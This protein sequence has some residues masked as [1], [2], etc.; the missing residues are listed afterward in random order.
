M[1]QNFSL[2]TIVKWNIEHV[3]IELYP[4]DQYAKEMSKNDVI[5]CEHLFIL[6]F[7][8]WRGTVFALRNSKWYCSLGAIAFWLWLKAGHKSDDTCVR[9]SQPRSLTR[10]RLQIFSHVS[11]LAKESARRDGGGSA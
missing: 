6:S 5:L 9:V 10:S 11:D 3:S 2:R 1:K 4:H 7:G 8:A